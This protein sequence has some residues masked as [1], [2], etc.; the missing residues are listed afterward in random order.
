MKAID[1]LQ[2]IAN[3]VSYVRHLRCSVHCGYENCMEEAGY[4][5]DN[6]NVIYH[7]GKIRRLDTVLV[8]NERLSCGKPN[9]I[10]QNEDDCSVCIYIYKVK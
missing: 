6:Y 8:T 7:Y 5:P 3:E 2:E 1:I 10:M 9:I 4:E